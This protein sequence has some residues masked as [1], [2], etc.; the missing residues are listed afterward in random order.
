G[1]T[2]NANDR[3]PGTI[4]P[5]GPKTNPKIGRRQA[6]GRDSTNGVNRESV[7]PTEPPGLPHRTWRAAPRVG[8]RSREK[9]NIVND[10]ALPWDGYVRL[11][12]HPGIEDT[13]AIPREHHQIVETPTEARQAEP[14]PSV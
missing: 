14:G 9:R 2:P 7:A 8:G 1:I 12:G 11:R 13:M 3:R 5:G 6:R 10:P 4:T